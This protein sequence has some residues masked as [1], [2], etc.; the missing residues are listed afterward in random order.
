MAIQ[1]HLSKQEGSQNKGTLPEVARKQSWAEG[2]RNKNGSTKT[3]PGSLK[4][5][6]ADKPLAKILED[7]STKVNQEIPNAKKTRVYKR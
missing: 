1:A 7:N 6:T 5:S 4:R 3:E 2:S